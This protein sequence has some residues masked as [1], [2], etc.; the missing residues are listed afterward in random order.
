MVKSVTIRIVLSIA[1]SRAWP[2][3]QLDL[4]NA[5]LHGFLNERVY[6]QQSVGFVDDLRS[7]HVCL[8]SKS[9]YGLKQAPWAWYERFATFIRSVGFF[10]D[11][12]RPLLCS[13]AR[14]HHG[15]STALHR[16]HCTHD[17]VH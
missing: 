9:L 1:S 4:N 3:H 8:L 7:D 15:G 10:F 14:A 5:F 12:I 6:C 17:I 13:P 16:Q 2:M 11:Q